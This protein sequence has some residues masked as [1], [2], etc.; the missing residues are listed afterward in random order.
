MKNKIIIFL[1]I[2]MVCLVLAGCSK[3][4]TSSTSGTTEEGEDYFPGISREELVEPKVTSSAGS[5]S[6]SSPSKSTVTTNLKV[7]ST[8]QIK[9]ARYSLEGVI[10]VLSTSS[11]SLDNFTYDGSC[12]GFNLYLTRSNSSNT[13]LVPF[14]IAN[15]SY[16]DESF[17]INF[18]SGVSIDNIDSV[19]MTCS[20]KEDP[21]F[22]EQLE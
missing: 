9:A 18:P 14:D 21:I 1:S 16:S 13:V 3:N 15:T 10:K 12:T 5:S 8:T 19:A 20:D 17:T 2:P 7:G 6:T 22:V 11:V 4:S